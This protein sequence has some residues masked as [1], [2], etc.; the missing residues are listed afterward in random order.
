MKFARDTYGKLCLVMLVATLLALAGVMYR[1]GVF[2]GSSGRQNGQ[3]K[4]L[5]RE[6]AYRARFELIE[7]LYAPVETLRKEGNN[8][9][10]LFKLDELAKK[11]PGEAHGYIL[12]GE[13]LQGMGVLEEAV[14]SYVEGVKLNGDYVDSRSPLSRRSAIQK[15]VEVGSSRVAQRMDANPD[16]RSVAVVQQKINYLKSRLAGGCE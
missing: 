12:Q 10:A 9:A 1:D 16:N 6:L 13:I 8:Q 4:A 3:H 7:K 5:E 15:V 14:T 11:Y 2:R